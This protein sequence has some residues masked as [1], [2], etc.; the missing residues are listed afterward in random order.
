MPGSSQATRTL[1]AAALAL[2]FAARAAAAPPPPDAGFPAYLLGLGFAPEA[3][4]ELERLAL[5]G[6]DDPALADVAA[7]V[8]ARLAREGRPAEAARALRL[9]AEG[10]ADPVLADQRRLALATVLFRAG[11]W[12]QGADVLSRV[13]AFGTS[14]GARERARRLLCVGQVLS[15]QAAPA[16]ACVGDLV[17]PGDARGAQAARMLDRLSIDPERRAVVGGILSG[18]LPGLGQATGGDPL[19]GG[20]ALLVNGGWEAGSTLLA[21]DG[22]YV[23]ATLLA[24]GV[25]LRYY[26]GNVHR[27]AAAWRGAAQRTRE[28]AARELARMVAATPLGSGDGAR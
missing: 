4:H 18:I 27:G 20:T 24:V 23:D 5:A 3:A 26:L 10:A 1:A 21:L 22:L 28:A 16:R 11:A 8:G 7:T 2:S 6:A 14:A 15:L 25:G 9:A 17:P 12:A 13:E 19:D